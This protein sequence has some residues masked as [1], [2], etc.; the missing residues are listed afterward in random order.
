MP[1]QGTKVKPKA[2]LGRRSKLTPDYVPKF[3]AQIEKGLP[4]RAAAALAGLH[5]DTVMKWLEAARAGD[6]RYFDFLERYTRARGKAQ[7]A[8]V[9]RIR[10]VGADDWR[11]EAWLLERM[12]PADFSLKQALELS[13]K[14]GGPVAVS[15]GVSV[16][17]ESSAPNG[18]GSSSRLTPFMDEREGSPWRGQNDLV[19]DAQGYIF[20]ATGK[21]LGVLRD[22]PPEC[23]PAIAP[24]NPAPPA[25]TTQ[26]VDHSAERIAQLTREIAALKTNGHGIP[27]RLGQ[28][29][30]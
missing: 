11:A 15:A 18:S 20:D 17:I 1:A 19:T 9:E 30:R 26:P 14:D 29:I 21:L 16:V 28:M 23:T 8:A 6:E 24:T 22:L 12:H 3:L 10:R 13:G 5:H 25:R 7:D 2:K 4:V 27:S